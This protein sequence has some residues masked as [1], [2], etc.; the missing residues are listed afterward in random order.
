MGSRLKLCIAMA[1]ALSAMQAQAI[2]LGAIEVKSKLD[3]PFVADIPVTINSPDEAN[4]LVVRLASADAFA[5]VGMNPTQL[6]ANLEFTVS[7]NA[8]GDTIVR[9]TTPQRMHDPYVTFLLEADWGKGKMVREYTALLDPPHTA[10][11]PRRAISAPVVASTPMPTPRAPMP[12]REQAPP[13]IQQVV[14]APAAAPLLPTRPLQVVSPPAPVPPPQPIAETPP[15]Q[16]LPPLSALNA[17]EPDPEPAPLPQPIAVAPTPEIPPPPMVATPTPEVPSQPLAAA[18]EPPPARVVRA[19]PPPAAEPMQAKAT[20]DSVTVTRGDTL[21]GIA[22]QVRPNEVTVNRMM[23]ALQREN[24]NAFIRANI[25]LLK[26][27]SVLQIPGSEQ[28]EALTAEEADTLVHEQIESWRQSAQPTPQLQPAENTGAV[29]IKPSRRTQPAGKTVVENTPAPAPAKAPVSDTATQPQPDATASAP[30]VAKRRGARLEIVPPVG[31]AAQV[32]QSGASEGGS[33]SELRAQLAQT[34]EELAT[35]NSEVGDLKSRVTDLEK[36]QKDSQKLLSMKDSQLAAMQ[37]RLAEV[38]KS[39]AMANA[40]AAST[41]VP[42]SSTAT[43]A[44]ATA[45]KPAESKPVVQAAKKPTLFPPTQAIEEPTPWYMRPLVLIGMVLLVL[46]AM[47][48]M[49]LRR[50]RDSE[51]TARPRGF[52]GNTQPTSLAA[53]RAAAIE[54]DDHEAEAAEEEETPVIAQTAQPVGKPQWSGG[55]DAKAQTA[56]PVALE[57]PATDVTTAGATAADGDSE[58]DWPIDEAPASTLA[59]KEVTKQRSAVPDFED[60]NQTVATKLELARAYIDIGDK[61]GARGML[62]EVLIEG[63]GSQQEAAFKLLDT[64]DS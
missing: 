10:Q 12:V 58:E 60:S 22:G 33:G 21:S 62:E 30:R 47:L 63:N 32:S 36:M 8:R 31:N 42:P 16:L 5:R 11:V 51:A 15:S 26:S 29:A 56:T 19:P 50:P 24:P 49:M 43:V 41:P 27:G 59:A 14:V 1:F 61:D 34:K 4:S 38:E 52:V 39:N 55:F 40:A 3:Q 20:P 44:P 57:Q 35:R 2:G 48:G 53:A 7:K 9:V 18:P 45:V 54:E 17:T 13:P 6:S 37:Q 23:I 46:A 25:N 64:L 28:T